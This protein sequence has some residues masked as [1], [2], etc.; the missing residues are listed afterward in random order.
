MPF[1]TPA[2]FATSSRRVTLSGPRAMISSS[3]AATIAARRSAARSARLE[4]GGGVGETTVGALARAA[5]LRGRSSPDFRVDGSRCFI[6]LH[7]LTDWSVIVKF[8]KK[9]NRASSRR[10][11]GPIPRDLSISA[12]WWTP[13][14]KP[15]PGV[16]GPG[17][18]L[19]AARWSGTPAADFAG[20]FASLG[21]NL[22]TVP[23]LS[24]SATGSAEWPPDDRLRRTIQYSRGA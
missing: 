23:P 1:A 10:T 6:M 16:M 15:F 8:P 7:M 18:A 5:L 19:A 4:A 12:P 2:R 13:S 11:P 20:A 24:S 9:E 21:F 17:S 14:A 22:Q 3:A